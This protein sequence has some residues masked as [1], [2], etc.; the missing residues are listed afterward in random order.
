MT[1]PGFYAVLG[2]K[3][4]GRFWGINVSAVEDF[5][6]AAVCDVFHKQYD[7]EVATVSSHSPL[8]YN[9]LLYS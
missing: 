4:S 6:L 5:V 9:Y 1:T 2:A 3:E 7:E 8:N